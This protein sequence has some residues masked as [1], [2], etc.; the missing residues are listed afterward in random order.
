MAI[1]SRFLASGSSRAQRVFCCRQFEGQLPDRALQFSDPKLLGREIGQVGLWPSHPPSATSAVGC[2]PPSIIKSGTPHGRRASS[3][4]QPRENSMLAL[5]SIPQSDFRKFK[6][7]LSVLSCNP[8][9][10]VSIPQSE[11]CKFS[12]VSLP[13]E[14]P[15]GPMACG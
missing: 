12:N 1:T 3:R 8:L 15:D 2:I 11:F 14:I 7:Q 5:V 4:L 9:F 10:F 6:R 13:G